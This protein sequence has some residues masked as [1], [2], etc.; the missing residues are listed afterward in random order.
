[1]IIKERKKSN[2]YRILESLYHRM[3]LSFSEKSQYENQ[4]K[5]FNGEIAFDACLSNS[6]ISSQSL[7]INDLL[8]K[9]LDTHYQIDSLLITDDHIYLYE[10]KNYS[11]SYYYKDGSIYSESGH[12]LQS[13]LAQADRKKAYLYNL[14]LKSNHQTEISSY[15]VYINPECYMY[16]LPKNDSFIFSGQL[17]THFKNLTSHTPSYSAKTQIWADELVRLHHENYYSTNLPDYDFD[18]LK[19][20]IYCSECFSFRYESTR[21]YRMC[22]VCG[23]REKI[24]DAILRNIEEF[25]LLF[26]DTHLT[27]RLIH[28]WCGNDWSKSRIQDSLKTHYHRHYAGRGTYYS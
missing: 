4:I 26:P 22:T 16:S 6:S 3:E 12:V 8:L 15:V 2:Q 14:L 19:K 9:T 27:K 13:H 17:P 7:I 24:A 25:R 18:T 10:V 5:G 1:M 28:E 21:Q 20:G 11:G 23:C